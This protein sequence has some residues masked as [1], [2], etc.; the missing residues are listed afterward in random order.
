MISNADHPLAVRLNG[1]GVDGAGDTGDGAA[2]VHS[3]HV[4]LLSGFT[5]V[6]EVGR[7]VGVMAWPIDSCDQALHPSGLAWV[8]LGRDVMTKPMASA[9]KEKSGDGWTIVT[10]N[11]GGVERAERFFKS[12]AEADA[13]LLKQYALVREEG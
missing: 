1:L 12:E 13:Y 8:N 4:G 9:G 6:W 10:Q 2:K 5:C 7:L 3:D 11:V